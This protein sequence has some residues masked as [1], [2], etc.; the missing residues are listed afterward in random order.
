MIRTAEQSATIEKL[1]QSQPGKL[2]V[3]VSSVED[4]STNEQAKKIIDDVKPDWI[5]WSAGKSLN[6][7]FMSTLPLS[8]SQLLS[9]TF[10]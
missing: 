2:N 9:N 6:C 10:F 1:G 4:V 8:C 5:V 7:L 3:L